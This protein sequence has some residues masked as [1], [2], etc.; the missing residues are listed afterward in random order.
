MGGDIEVFWGGGEVLGGKVQ[1][2][3]SRVQGP[4]QLLGYALNILQL[5]N[6]VSSVRHLKQLLESN[7]K[8]PMNDHFIYVVGGLNMPVYCSSLVDVLIIQV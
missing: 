3:E 8:C 2:P 4:V 6:L 7:Y 5:L 1:S